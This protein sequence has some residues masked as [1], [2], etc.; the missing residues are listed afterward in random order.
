MLRV[1]FSGR[2]TPVGCAD[3]AHSPKREHPLGH[4]RFLLRFLLGR[5]AFC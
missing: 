3:A 5:L 2:P 4:V 1:P